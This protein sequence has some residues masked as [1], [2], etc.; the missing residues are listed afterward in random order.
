[1]KS[2]FTNIPIDEAVRVIFEKMNEN[3]DLVSDRTSLTT[4][5]IADLLELCLRST[6]FMYQI[7][8]GLNLISLISST[9]CFES[10]TKNHP[11]QTMVISQMK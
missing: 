1:M 3:E 7:S 4:D 11:V 6:Y 8:S 10:L 9:K 5:R 2:L